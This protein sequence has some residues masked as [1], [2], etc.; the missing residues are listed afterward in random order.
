MATIDGLSG[1]QSM[2]ALS[3]WAF[4]LALSLVACGGSVRHSAPL[5]ARQP[6]PV[7]EW[8]VSAPGLEGVAGDWVRAGVGE[9]HTEKLQVLV[10]APISRDMLHSVGADEVGSIAP[11]FN[12]NQLGLVNSV[13]WAAEPGTGGS[14]Q[15][16]IWWV[17]S[18]G[19]STP[20]GVIVGVWRID[21][22]DLWSPTRFEGYG[23]ML[24]DPGR[25]SAREDDLLI[26]TWLDDHDTRT[27]SRRSDSPA[28]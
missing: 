14:P 9:W 4:A 21:G 18:V 3:R 17:A 22:P 20:D 11:S 5:P 27:F 19:R 12:T 15:T 2:M 1:D 6:A 13:N 23:S 28:E 24:L 8:V 10:D 25:S 16:E 7:G 26:V